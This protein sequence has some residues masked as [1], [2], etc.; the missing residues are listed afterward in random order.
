MEYYEKIRQIRQAHG[1]N[2]QFL[3]DL[4]QTTQ[5]QISK[6]EN[7]T[8]E[9]PIRRLIEFCKHYNVSADYILGLPKN[10]QT[11]A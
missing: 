2:Q 4:F 6:Y 3:A 10:P 1:D 5:H 7:G 9:L 11:P 8:Q